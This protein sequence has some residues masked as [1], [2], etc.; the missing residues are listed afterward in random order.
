MNIKKF[1]SGSFSIFNMDFALLVLRLWAGLSLFVK[2]G[3]E[4][5]T[6]FPGMLSRFPDPIHIGAAPSLTFALISDAIC[7]VLIAIGWFTRIAAAFEVINLLVIFITLH[8]F[9]FMQEHA[10]IVYLYLGIYITIFFS[11]P[12]KYS[13]DKK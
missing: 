12:G 8:S 5:F 3:I 7:T 2:H 6:D 13:L 9:S 4:K 11:G 10:E 1:N